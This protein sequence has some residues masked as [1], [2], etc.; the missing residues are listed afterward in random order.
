MANELTAMMDCCKTGQRLDLPRRVITV[1]RGQLDVHVLDG[2]DGLVSEN[3]E[4]LD[5]S[6]CEWSHLGTP[7]RYRT[8]CFAGTHEWD[9]NHT[10]VAEPPSNGAAL[11]VFSCVAL[12]IS[13]LDRFL[14]IGSTADERPARQG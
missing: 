12:H 10:A 5:L 3:L 1:E 14:V 11:G 4:Q 6:V 7:D 8:E 9:G 13:D 2:D